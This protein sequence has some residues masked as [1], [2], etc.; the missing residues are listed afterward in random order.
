MALND[1]VLD[2]EVRHQVGLHRLATGIVR[3]IIKL[4]D[5]VDADIVRKIQLI[6]EDTWTLQR[7]ERLLREVRVLNAA[8]YSRLSVELRDDLKALATYERDYQ[9]EQLRRV[10]PVEV[11]WQRP[12]VAQLQAAVTVRPF[13]GAL[14]REWVAGLEEGRMR[15]LREAI[16][17]GFVEGETIGQIVRRVRGTQAARFKDG[18]LS[19]SRRS[20]EAMVRTAVN[21]TAT[22]ARDLVFEQNESVIKGVQWVSTL[23]LRTTPICRARDGKVYPLNSGPRPPAHINCRSTI[24]PVVKSWQELGLSG[25]DLPPA[26]RASMNGQ[27]AADLSYGDWL[28]KQP[29]SVQDEVLGVAKGRLFRR[30]ELPIDRFVDESGRSYTLDELRRR[31][32]AAWRRAGLEE[33]A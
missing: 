24:T 10:V 17:I 6:N 22:A 26:T 29:A 15:R 7:L 18:A 32:S 11:N 8:A 23:D 1:D 21:H 16:R 14:L 20:A 13:M 33:A 19:I 27:V 4:L 28:L 25:P 30:G 3:R 9:V 12:T 31:E 5:A 2:I